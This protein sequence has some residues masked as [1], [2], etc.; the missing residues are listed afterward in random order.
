MSEREQDEIDGTREEERDGVGENERIMM[1]K[2]RDEEEKRDW[3]RGK[4]G[5]LP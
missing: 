5:S 3:E 2:E 4:R 1:E